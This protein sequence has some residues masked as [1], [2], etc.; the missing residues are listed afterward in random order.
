[1]AGLTSQGLVIKTTNEVISELE[2][3]ARTLFADQVPEGEVVNT[4]S[5]T[6]LGRMIGV[7]SP[8]QSDIWEAIQEVYDAFTVT[9]ATGFALDN[10]VALGGISRLQATPTRASILVT[11]NT[12]LGIPAGS[13]VSSST[14][15]A[16]Y[17]SPLLAGL[18]T[19]NA[20]G[21]GVSPISVV[22]STNYTISYKSSVDVVYTDITVNSGVGASL[23]SLYSLFE[24]EI[25]L[26]H[27]E[28]K[29]RQ[30]N[31]LLFV[32]SVDPFQ[33]FTY[34][35]SSNIGIQKV[36]KPVLFECDEVGPVV[37]PAGT[38]DTIATPIFGWDSAVNPVDA[39]TGNYTET[40]D[41]LRERFRNSKFEK[42]TNVIESLYS[43]ILQLNGVEDLKIYENDT[44]VVDAN[45]VNGHSFLVVCEG[46]LGTEIAQSIWDNKPVGILSQGNT[47]VTVFDSQGLP[48]DVSFSRPTKI[49]TYIS[50]NITKDSNFPQ[51]GETKIKSE[52]IKYI[53]SLK[54]GEDVVYSRLYTPINS[55]S[56]FQVDSLKI[57]T[58]PSPTGT[59][60]IVIDFDEISNVMESFIVITET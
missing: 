12:N 2:A 41:E 56:G 59:S 3:L 49:N 16:V 50:I 54:I 25:A 36:I 42:A 57:G 7:V 43:S 39:T 8:P 31:N 46:G 26:N 40:D 32:E 6:T 34:E 24:A 19:T 11:G 44:D 17:S 10:L 9:S 1:M 37:Q 55:V 15:G 47:T 27:T 21:V 5:N 22:D 14:T 13:K 28:L 33:L 52:M 38:I 20:T 45:G 23:L 18:S 4:G 60:N 30:V 29:T 35:S 53:D 48:H 51:D 58:S